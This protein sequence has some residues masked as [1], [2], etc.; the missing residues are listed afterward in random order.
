MNIYVTNYGIDTRYKKYM[1]SYDEI[2]NILKNKKVAI[3]C[4]AKLNTQNR[5]SS[6]LAK[7]EL[8]RH[9]IIADI[10]DLNEKNFIIK[11]IIKDGGY[12]IGSVNSSKTYDSFQ[13]K[14]ITIE[15]N[16]YFENQRNVRLWNKEQFDYFFKDYDLEVLEEITTTRWNKTKIIWEFIAKVKK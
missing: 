3:I 4:N 9:D 8:N 12:F 10:I 6:I 13:G 11:R 7:E 1:N 16:Y 5:T 14:A 2:I 15:P